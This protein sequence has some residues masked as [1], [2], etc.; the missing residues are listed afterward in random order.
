MVREKQEGAK[1]KDRTKRRARGTWRKHSQNC[2]VLRRDGQPAGEGSPELGEV[3][4]GWARETEK[5]QHR[6]GSRYL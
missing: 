2:S 4:S 5:S 3:D 6:L 1:E